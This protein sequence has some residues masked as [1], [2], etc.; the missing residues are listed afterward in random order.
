MFFINILFLLTLSNNNDSED[1]I[2]TY[3]T[4]FHDFK[5]NIENYEIS[6]HIS[7]SI[8]KGCHKSSEGGAIYY[9]YE[10][11]KILIE[12]STFCN[13]YTTGVNSY[14]GAISVKKSKCVVYCVCSNGCFAESQQGQFIRTELKEI[15]KKPNCCNFFINIFNYVQINHNWSLLF[16][17]SLFSENQYRLF[18]S[19]NSN[20]SLIIIYQIYPKIKIIMAYIIVE[21][22]P[23]NRANP[24]D[25][26]FASCFVKIH[27]LS[28]L[29]FY[30]FKLIL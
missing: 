30:H 3:N 20:S 7:N 26:V 11:G 12:F 18:V 17:H 16:S 9:S 25:F 5:E 28:P 21:F 4:K 23:S 29:S 22:S 13:C 2:E 15:E 8:F 6:V 1:S 14:G 24:R 10:N 19:L 27:I